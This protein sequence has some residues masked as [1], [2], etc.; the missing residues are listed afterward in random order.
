[1]THLHILVVS[2]AMPSAMLVIPLFLLLLSLRA[3]VLLAVLMA[4]VLR[5]QV[6]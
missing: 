2:G 6:S 3:A 1:M 4:T 5:S